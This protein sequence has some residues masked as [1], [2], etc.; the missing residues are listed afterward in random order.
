MTKR[1]VLPPGPLFSTSRKSKLSKDIFS[2]AR[3]CY[4]SKCQ[5]TPT[6]TSTLKCCSQQCRQGESLFKTLIRLT[7]RQIMCPLCQN[8]LGIS[9]QV[10]LLSSISASPDP[11]VCP[12]SP[13]PRSSQDVQ[14]P[15]LLS[16]AVLLSALPAS[17]GKPHGPAVC[18]TAKAEMAPEPAGK[19]LSMT[20]PVGPPNPHASLL[21]ALWSISCHLSV[22]GPLPPPLLDFAK[23]LLSLSPSCCIKHKK[24]RWEQHMEPEAHVAQVPCCQKGGQSTKAPEKEE[25]LILGPY[26]LKWQCILS[27]SEDRAASIH[28]W[29]RGDQ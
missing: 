5:P 14:L 18:R 11:L 15:V 12:K 6:L 1:N 16:M 28:L 8:S 24:Q 20:V 29:T 26:I 22:S 7:D 25:E 17:Q 13:V 2:L 10:V 19:L 27:A 3:L 23:A 9:K 4:C 21:S